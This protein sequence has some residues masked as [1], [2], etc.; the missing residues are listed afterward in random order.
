M[1]ML[2][3][4]AI[5]AHAQAKVWTHGQL[6]FTKVD[7]TDW[8]LP[9]NQDRITDE[10]WITR[11][12]D[13]GIFNIKV[14][15]SYNKGTRLSPVGTEWAVGD[16]NDWDT[17]NYQTFFDYVLGKAGDN[18]LSLGSSVVHL[19]DEDIYIAIEF[20]AWTESKLGGGFTYTRT[21]FD[22]TPVEP[23]TWGAIKSL[24]Q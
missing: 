17:L 24:Y 8:T 14:E 22:P 2:S 11:Q 13:A 5:D 20:T 19:I 23:S 12:H 4:A 10:V 7:S 15:S 9:A 18:I 6:T 16:I 1:A 3:T 21:T